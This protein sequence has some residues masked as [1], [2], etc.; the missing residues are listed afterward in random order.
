MADR[1]PDDSADWHLAPIPG[2]SLSARRD[3]RLVDW[4]IAAVAGTA[5]LETGRC[6]AKKDEPGATNPG[7]FPWFAGADSVLPHPLSL[8]EIH[9]LAA[10]AG[11]GGICK[12]CHYIKRHLHCRWNAIWVVGRTGLVQPPGW[13]QY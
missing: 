10:A 12:R 3:S 6:P 4:S 11:L 2:C 8:A 9:E 5:S 7:V 13:V 1:N